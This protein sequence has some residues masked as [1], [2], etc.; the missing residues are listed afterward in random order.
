VLHLSRTGDPAVIA[1]TTC[2]ILRLLFSAALLSISFNLRI[3]DRTPSLFFGHLLGQP[4]E[5]PV[6]GWPSHASIFVHSDQA[7]GFSVG[8]SA[9]AGVVQE[10][11]QIAGGV[12]AS[13]CHPT[14]HGAVVVV[15]VVFHTSLCS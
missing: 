5:L 4:L 14:R 3:L 2:T 12:A 11:F 6:A 9:G 8:V 15:S 10:G 1:R 13:C 7:V